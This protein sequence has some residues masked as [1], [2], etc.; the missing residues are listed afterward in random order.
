MS[1][2]ELNVTFIDKYMNVRIIWIVKLTALNI[3]S[4][5]SC[6]GGEKKFSGPLHDS[7]DT[8]GCSGIY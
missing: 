5:I 1:H 3:L 7:R 8:Q 6:L 2:S 4:Q